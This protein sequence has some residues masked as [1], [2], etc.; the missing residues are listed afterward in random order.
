MYIDVSVH[1]GTI[2]W[3]KVKAAGV[4]GAIIRCG[5]GDNK[6]SQDDKKF[7]ENVEGCIKNKIPFGVYIYSYAK[8]KAQAQSEAYHVIRLLKK[9]KSKIELP[10]YLDLEEKG[11]EKGAVERAKVFCKLV[12]AEGYKV[13]IYANEYWWLNHLKKLTKYPKWVAKYSTT[14]PKVAEIKM[15][16]YTET[17]KV[18]GIKG[19][20]DCSKL[21]ATTTKTATTTTKTATTTKKTAK[22]YTIKAGDT[23]SAIAKKNNTTVDKLAKLNGIKDVNKIYAGQVIKLC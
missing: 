20:V 2:D 10:V 3:K 12:K 7:T 18:D 17:G 19:N 13:G 16:Q 21:M 22:T 23:L 14:K 8:T 11:T 9:Y 4:K 1:N 15:W 5:Y 6:V